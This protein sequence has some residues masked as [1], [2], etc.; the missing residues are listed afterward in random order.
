M[1]KKVAATAAA[2]GAAGFIAAAAVAGDHGRDFKTDLTAS[3]RSRPSRRSRARDVKAEVSR[4]G[5]EIRYRLSYRNLEGDVQ[6]S[7][8]HLGQEGVN[9]GIVVFLCSNLGNGP[10]GTPACPP[11]P[12]TVTGTLD[13]ADVRPAAGRAKGIGQG[14]FDELVRAMRAG[15]TYANVHSTKFPGGE[16]RG[17]FDREHAPTADA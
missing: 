14:E 15:V 5:K 11:S 1:V 17:Q 8:I 12:A 2:I 3:R 9:G 13:A 6:Q 7:H 16:V 4:D 10:A